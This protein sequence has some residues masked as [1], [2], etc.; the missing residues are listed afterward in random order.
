[1]DTCLIL[2]KPMRIDDLFQLEQVENNMCLVIVSSQCCAIEL[3]GLCFIPPG[4]HLIQ[5]KQ[6]SENSLWP[7]SL[8]ARRRVV[9]AS[10]QTA[11]N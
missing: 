1:M 5:G 7:V 10:P 9:W 4:L 6:K 11:T 8:F 2:V 3:P